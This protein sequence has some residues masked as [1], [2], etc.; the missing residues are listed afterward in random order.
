[1]LMPRVN[2]FACQVTSDIRKKLSFK[3]KEKHIRQ[4]NNSSSSDQFS[5]I[6]SYQPFNT[7]QFS[8]E[9]SYIHN[10]NEL[11]YVSECDYQKNSRYILGSLNQHI[12]SF[13]ARINININPNLTTQYWGQPFLTSGKYDHFKKTTATRAKTYV[14]RFQVFNSQHITTPDPDNYY[15]VDENKDGNYDYKFEN[16]DFNFNEFLSNLVLRWEYLPGS[17]LY[18]VWS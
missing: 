2:T 1:M 15:L 5:P 9:P 10:K 13:S 17:A 14:D 16:P 7:L 3:Y 8:F 4:G 12:L 11:Q 6:I 18:L